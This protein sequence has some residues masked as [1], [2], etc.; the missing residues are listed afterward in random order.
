MQTNILADSEFKGDT[1]KYY[2]L[3]ALIFYSLLLSFFSSPSVLGLTESSTF[4]HTF[5]PE[6]IWL[7]TLIHPRACIA[8][9]EYAFLDLSRYIASIFNLNLFSLRI[10]PIV[11]GIISLCFF[12]QVLIRWC[13]PFIALFTSGLLAANPVFLMFPSAMRELAVHWPLTKTSFRMGTN[14]IKNIR[15]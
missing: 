14:K 12:Y 15:R 2:H 5:A 8:G 1:F 10:L 13:A 7:N 4:F 6:E 11:C 9:Y 3:T